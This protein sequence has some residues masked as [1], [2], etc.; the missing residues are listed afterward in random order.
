MDQTDLTY[1]IVCPS[2]RQ[3]PQKLYNGTFR[4]LVTYLTS[5]PEWDELA[6]VRAVFRWVTS[7][8]VFSLNVEETPSR[9]SPMEYFIKIQNNTGNHAHLFS[10]LC[11]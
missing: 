1:T 4:E 8:D 10:G 11:Q 2:L 3:T 6:K 5:N 9:Q 7:V